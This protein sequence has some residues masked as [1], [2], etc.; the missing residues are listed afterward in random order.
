MRHGDGPLAIIIS[1]RM[2]VEARAGSSIDGLAPSALGWVG[3][4]YSSVSSAVSS[5]VDAAAWELPRQQPQGHAQGFETAW[6]SQEGNPQNKGRTT[7]KK[8]SLPIWVVPPP[9]TRRA[10]PVLSRAP[11]AKAQRT[12]ISERQLACSRASA[13]VGAPPIKHHRRA[14]WIPPRFSSSSSLCCLF[15]VAVGTAGDGGTN[16]SCD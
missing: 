10:E 16:Q 11:R 5:A 6:N 8:T 13:S 7:A 1:F 14:T 2:R 12:R 15:S 4:V 3:F 9:A